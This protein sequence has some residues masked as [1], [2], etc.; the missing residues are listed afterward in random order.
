G[1]ATQADV[2]RLAEVSQTTVSM[3]LNGTGAAQR[4]VSESVRRR[5]LEAIEST[6]YAANPMAQRLVGGRTS[7]IG[8][9]TYES[10]FPHSAGNFYRPFLEGVENEAEH[11]EV[12]LML[13][14]SMSATPRRSLLASGVG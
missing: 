4:R 13:F 9:Y 6:G 3:V 12:D 11:A 1:R 5:V 10:V 8:V 2:A 7:I 14:T